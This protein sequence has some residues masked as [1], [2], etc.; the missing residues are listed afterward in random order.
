[1]DSC[2]ALYLKIDDPIKA[3]KEAGIWLARSGML[4]PNVSAECGAI[5][6]LDAFAKGIP[7]TETP[8]NYWIVAGRMTMKPEAMLARFNEAG[9]KHKIVQNDA[10]ACEIKLE[11]ESE[12]ETFRISW[13]QAQQETWPFEKNGK[14]IKGTWKGPVGRADMLWART[15]SRGVRKLRP[16]LVAGLYTPEEIQDLPEYA[17]AIR[18]ES[19][20]GKALEPIDLDE[21]LKTNAPKQAPIAPP[22]AAKEVPT[23][24]P[25]APVASNPAKAT[26]ADDTPQVAVEQP[27]S[28]SDALPE[29][30]KRIT[31]LF[32][33]LSIPVEARDAAL[34][35]RGVSSVRSLTIAQADE[36][37]ANLEAKYKAA[38]A[39]RL[40]ENVT[41]FP[42]TAP[43][44]QT[45]IDAVKQ[46]VAEIA[47]GNAG[48]PEKYKSYLAKQGK[49]RT[50]DLNVREADAMLATLR[51]ENLEQFFERSLTQMVEDHQ[52]DCEPPKN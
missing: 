47:E 4:G 22:S 37:L 29:Q 30:V 39:S 31:D 5:I 24:E 12:S 8:L 1:M 49:Q 25:A 13:E 10:D 50:A 46:M 20:N 43:C 19:G 15:V 16:A 33:E 3:S 35:K 11:I 36:L 7:I 2:T 48:F 21:V 17:E 44:T 42:V 23:S 38:E 34:K 41:S 28:D 18:S 26:Q 14:T 52:H 32:V 6:A 27:A 9:G 51:M 45:Q 40:P